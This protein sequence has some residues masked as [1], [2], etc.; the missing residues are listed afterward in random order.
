MTKRK[1]DKDDDTTDDDDDDDGGG[2]PRRKKRRK[3]E[4]ASAAGTVRRVLSCDVGR[5]H[6]AFV[7]ATLQWRNDGRW[8]VADVDSCWCIDV[9]ALPHR[10]V[11]R[12]CCTLQHTRHI[13]DLVAHMLQELQDAV[14]AADVFCLEQQPPG[15]LRDI[16][17]LL[18]A[19]CR[20]KVVLM[21]PTHMHARLGMRGLDY[22]QR[23]Q[24][25]TERADVLLRQFPH[26]AAAF[27]R[28]PR[29]HDAADALMYITVYADE[30]APPKLT[31]PTAVVDVDDPHQSIE[32]FRF[33]KQ[34]QRP[35]LQVPLPLQPPSPAEKISQLIRAQRQCTVRA[36][37]M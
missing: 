16:E 25:V 3:S 11:S 32:A 17:A 15:G 4:A 21:S 37:T 28:L 14:A 35:P 24:F 36:H 18:F 5:K 26:A 1:R 8:H 10:R 31:T 33:R 12:A 23:K 6:C 13:V 34:Q 27:E 7:S 9:D 22:D 20:D 30:L 2:Q 29:L 19:A